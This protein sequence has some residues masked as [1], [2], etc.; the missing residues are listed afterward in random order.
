MRKIQH[1]A[2]VVAGTG[3]LALGGAAVAGSG[4]ANAATNVRVTSCDTSSSAVQL[5]AIPK[6]TS[7]GTVRYPTRIKLT[8]SSAQLSLLI[9]PIAGGVGQG[10]KDQWSMSCY[11]GTARII[12]KSGTFEVTS[13]QTKTSTILPL[14][15]QTPSYCTVTSTVSTILG[16][17]QT[18]IGKIQALG[19]S[20]SVTAD[21]ASDNA[22]RNYNS[23][24]TWCADAA[25]GANLP[26]TMVMAWK[27]I[28]DP[29]QRWIYAPNRELVHE[30]RCL[31][32]NG[33]GQAVLQACTGAPGQ[34]W[35]SSGSWRLL[36][37]KD[38]RCL[39][40]ARYWNG[41]QLRAGSCR[42]V[43]AQ[44]WTIPAQSSY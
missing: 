32:Y 13:G 42:F 37:S 35:N 40:V 4:V 43:T 36:R 29:A 41:T 25:G 11:A 27:C 30:G 34:I 31:G 8:V 17:S 39:T 21:T 38:G 6:C 2:A 16:A 24:R 22:V 12:S 33:S 26:G 7:S 28:S 23:A 19:V 15:G 1:I 5:G 20:D 3:L 18:L 9:N 14:S 10:I 44:R